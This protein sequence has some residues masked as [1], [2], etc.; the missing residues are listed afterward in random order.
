MYISACLFV[1]SMLPPVPMTIRC[2]TLLAPARELVP[3]GG[4]AVLMAQP[5]TYKT[6]PLGAN[7]NNLTP[8]SPPHSGED[9]VSSCPSGTPTSAAPHLAT[10]IASA[11]SFPYPP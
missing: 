9:G 5:E 8:S 10:P 6:Q 1:Q 2:R 11:A 7:R 3:S 4:F